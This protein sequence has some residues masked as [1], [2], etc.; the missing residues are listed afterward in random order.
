MSRLLH[1]L[2]VMTGLLVA[3]CG[4]LAVEALVPGQDYYSWQIVSGSP[5]SLEKIY[6]RYSA[7]PYV[8]IERRGELYVLR[9]GFWPS[10]QAARD[11]LAPHLG[12]NAMIRIAAYRPDAIVR[13]NWEEVPGAAITPQPM[14]TGVKAVEVNAPDLPL[15]PTKPASTSPA[16]TA[17]ESTPRAHAP[18]RE[19]L[20]LKPFN[21]ADYALA[22]NVF[23]GA[24][25]IERAFYLAKK[26]VDSV[27]SDI[28]WRRKLAH[29]SDWTKHPQL[30][31]TQWSYLFEHGDRSDEVVNAVLRLAPMTEQPELAIAA[32]KVRAARHDPTPAQWTDL[33]RLF[34]MAGQSK[35]GSLYFE[36]QYRNRGDLKFLE[37][38]AQMA[39]NA[40]EDERGMDLYAERARLPPFSMD[41]T[42]NA[43]VIFIRR[44]R[45]R[46]AYDLMQAVSHEV[47]ADAEEFWR[48][49]GNV[50][51]ELQEAEGAEKAYQHVA[52][53]PQARVGDWSRL[54][55]LVRQR[56]PKQ[57][58]DLAFEAYRRYG[59]ADNL[60]L[61]LGIYV[62]AGDF[63]GQAR[64]FKQINP[65]DLVL[66]ESNAQFLVQR[67]QFYQN[68]SEVDKAWLDFR[69]ALTLSPRDSQIAVSAL[70]F[71]ID[72]GRKQE[73]EQLLLALTPQAQKDDAYWL[74]FAAGYHALDRFREA[75]AW[76]RKEVQRSPDDNLLLL[77]YADAMSRANL[78]GM[79]ERVRRHAWLRLKDKY[80]SSKL[81]APLDDQPELLAMA[82][83]ILLNQP[84]D[85]GLAVVRQ[86][87]NQLR[88][89]PDAQTPT[90][91]TRDLI[92]G[93]AI[94]KEQ[95]QNARS[96]MWLN[97]ARQAGKEPVAPLW[98]ESQTALQ[99]NDTATMDRLL[100]QQADRLPVYNRYDTAYA[101][102]HW[103]Q[104]LDI[105]YQGMQNNEVDEPLH[106]RYRQHA[107]LHAHY[108]QMRATNETY[109]VLN[110]D[111]QQMEARLV[112]EPK[113]HLMLGWAQN[114]QSSSD[115]ATAP[116]VPGGEQLS[117]VGLRW[118]GGSG[119]TSASVFQRNEMA[120]N[121]GL[122]LAQ[123]WR[124]SQR[125]VLDGSAGLRAD[126]TDSLP[127]RVGGYEDYLRLGFNY[128]ISKREYL[129]YGTRLARFSTQFGDSLGSGQSHNLELG[130]RIR[131]EY[132]DF[133]VRV[134]AE[135]YN[136]TYD[137]SV[138]AQALSRLSPEILGQ[139]NAGNLEAVKYFLPQGTTTLGACL[140][141]GE[142]LAGQNIQDIYTRA[143]RPFFDVCTTDNSLNG[144]GYSGMI[145]L[146]G[147]LTG[148]DHLSIRLE[149]SSG[150]TGSGAL[151]RILALRYRH[152]F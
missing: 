80:P 99:L 37:Q 152:Y 118:L 103:P 131:T 145:G 108:V 58:A 149:Q 23:M 146:A 73:L 36:R 79:A 12:K 128:A 135:Q 30:A 81:Q 147:A 124:W 138:G 68:Q 10:S 113:W 46:D 19:A 52:H 35:E 116:F 92:L 27:P 132:P 42:L 13:R 130:Y 87:V 62:Q 5:Q 43:V 28:D 140:G 106:D 133:R 8:R 2:F 14:P 83:L 71:L 31:W 11:A 88:G 119:E 29:V 34:D 47:R 143:L 86:V 96:W 9:A 6:P 151:S 93:W 102:E 55:Y 60:M 110:V 17:I 32:W 48:F 107:P 126:S 16:A 125:L 21:A 91:Q 82:R 148:E 141:M 95:F 77:S 101:L 74:S 4:A 90:R 142:N 41:A 136:Y 49:L 122:K 56:H 139:I 40:G 1:R 111:S 105:A 114:I 51:W 112:L 26:A 61:A 76:Y 15:R 120:G 85:P 44:D 65:S 20:E 117:S 97:Y 123:I 78:V 59:D 70:W 134:Y 127:L 67:G 53:D 24:G 38:A 144:A 3:A 54:I 115:A 75:L 22:F 33:Y 66:L 7:L 98:G 129:R 25:E 39:L 84:G 121:F 150:G 50:A 63:A 100:L 109:G 57:G 104:A 89:L 64:I 94:S 69:R 72:K 18:P 45:M 137:G